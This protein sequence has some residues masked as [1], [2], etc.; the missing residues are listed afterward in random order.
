MDLLFRIALSNVCISP[1]LA[2]AAMVVESTFRRPR[3][4]HLLWLLVFVK[5]LTP[6]VVS[7][8]V[9]TIP[10][11]ADLGAVAVKDPSQVGMDGSA[12]GIA[13]QTSG[14]ERDASGS[15]A[16]WHAIL[17]QAKPV[18][19]LIWWLGSGVVLVWSLVRVYRFNRL[20]AMESDVGPEALQA[21]AARIAGRLGLKAVPAIY[22]TCA[23]LSPMVWWIGGNVRVVVPAALLDRMDSRQSQW[24]LA[25][26]LA[27]VRRR[28]YLVRWLEWLACVLFWWNPLVWWARYRLRANEELCCAAPVLSVGVEGAQG[29]GAYCAVNFEVR[30]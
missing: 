3:L 5:L 15:G 28:D 2:V 25:H 6:P 18:L 12:D 10:D 1:A 13:A 22:T 14:G 26:E 20:L 23:H 11:L 29:R 16:I 24:I 21:V 9:V 4:A 30:E 8:P 19:S 27:H 7:I 17:A